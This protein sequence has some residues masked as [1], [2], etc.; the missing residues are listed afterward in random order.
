MRH[1]DQG[2]GKIGAGG[3]S[4]R[5]TEIS[6]VIPTRNRWNSVIRC[7]ESIEKQDDPPGFEVIVVDDG[8]EEKRPQALNGSRFDFP[9]KVIRQAN[10]GV[11]VARNNGAATA[12]SEIV[13]FVDSDCRLHPRCLRAMSLSFA[14]HPEDDAFQARISGDTACMIGRIEELDRSVIQR[15]LTLEN[16]RIRWLNTSGFAIRRSAFIADGAIFDPQAQRGQ[17]TMLLAR[18]INRGQL[19]RFAS[20]AVVRHA[21]Q[22][23]TWRYVLSG[24]PIGYRTAWTRRHVKKA[25]KVYMSHGDRCRLLA[26]FWKASRQQSIGT[27]PFCLLVLRRFAIRAGICTGNLTKPRD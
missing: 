13:F 1:G 26:S 11:S 18:L 27:V 17:D 15:R 7:L 14:S 19:P 20:E 10:A 25:A 6:V 3:K 5:E 8:S 16:G 22:T 9:L 2:T 21:P 24:F 12:G 4:D 23:T